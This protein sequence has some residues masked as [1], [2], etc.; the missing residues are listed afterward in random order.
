MRRPSGDKRHFIIA[1]VA[2]VVGAVVVYLG[3]SS[4]LPLPLAASTQAAT[5]DWLFNLH[6]ILISAL[7][8]LVVVF[9]LYAVFVFR[10]REGDDGDGDHF[11]GNTTLEIAWTVIP[12]VLVVIFGYI[13]VTSLADILRPADNELVVHVQAQ[14]WSWS[15]TYP[16]TDVTSAELILPVNQPANMEMNSSDVIHAFWVP[17]FRLKKDI[18]PGTTTSVRFTP[19]VVGEYTLDC[20][21]LCGLS[22]FSMVQKVKV[23]PPEE[24]QAWMGA[25][26]AK[27]TTQVA[28][29]AGSSDGGSS[30]DS[31]GDG[32]GDNG[33]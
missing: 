5:V 29:S 10:K 13:G 20:A 9:M 31:S 32:S 16:E 3:L 14:Q 11:E 7:F 8:A 19:T 24:F 22:H 25:E 33:F 18:V 21:E 1:G 17:E 26:V 28:T 30:A 12:L 23:V 4:A 2:T 15:F 27:K 6:I